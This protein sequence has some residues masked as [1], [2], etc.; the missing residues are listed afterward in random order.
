[1]KPRL[2]TCRKCDKYGQHH[3]WKICAIAYNERLDAL[4]KMN[5]PLGFVFNG[6]IGPLDRP[7]HPDFVVP[8]SCPNQLEHIMESEK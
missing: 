6:V 3:E 5:D 4:H 1:M 2:K 7:N 8:D